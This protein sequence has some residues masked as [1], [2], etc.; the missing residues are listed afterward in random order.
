MNQPDIFEPIQTCLAQNPKAFCLFLITIGVG[1]LLYA[2]FARDITGTA[3]F[4]D[5]VSMF[6]KRVGWI[7][8]G[9]LA[10]I[11]IIGGVI[12]FLFM[13]WKGNPDG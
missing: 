4:N 13:D 5:T 8:L 2:I 9:A 10:V 7:L 3:L 12:A 1:I 6:G 11:A